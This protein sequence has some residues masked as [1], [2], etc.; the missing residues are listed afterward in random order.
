[1]TPRQHHRLCLVAVA[2]WPTASSL[3]GVLEFGWTGLLWAVPGLVIGAILPKVV[4]ESLPIRCPRCAGR[5]EVATAKSWIRFPEG[6]T[7]I[8]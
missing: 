7:W 2:A 3:A 4:M 1:M 6:K 5:V 8:V